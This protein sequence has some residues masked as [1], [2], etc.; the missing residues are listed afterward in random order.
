[1]QE[2]GAS[3]YEFVRKIT[4]KLCFFES[5][6]SKYRKLPQMRPQNLNSLKN[7]GYFWY[8]TLLAPS[9]AYA[10]LKKVAIYIVK[11]LYQGINIDLFMYS[12]TI[13]DS[14]F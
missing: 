12:L 6:S 13:A 5:N 2:L 7:F 9:D 10:T 1:M 4:Q 11:L 8:K 14:I 3:P